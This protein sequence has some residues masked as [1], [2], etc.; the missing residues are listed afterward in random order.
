MDIQNSL[1][2][3]QASR[4]WSTPTPAPSDSLQGMDSAFSRLASPTSNDTIRP[5]SFGKFGGGVAWSGSSTFVLVDD[6]NSV[7]GGLI[8]AGARFCLKKRGECN[9]RS[10]SR[11]RFE[12]MQSGI[13]I[14]GVKEDAFCHPSVDADKF[15]P[16]ALQHVLNTCFDDI[17]EARRH[18]ELL[19]G[20]EKAL[21]SSEDVINL[22]QA[23]SKIEAFTP[24]KKRLKIGHL[25][26][27]LDQALEAEEK[28]PVTGEEI[29]PLKEQPMSLYLTE[30]TSKV[31]ETQQDF[32]SVLDELQ[33]IKSQIGLAPKAGPVSL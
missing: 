33:E 10:H 4:F 28:P 12:E 18:V 31:E 3:A 9:V 11:K 30:L 2:K 5:L 1:K 8:G 25:R 27:K 7:W 22:V 6:C 13:F 16:E 23:K 20:V 26:T 17:M 15:F 21:Q 24:V 19:K 14:R 29:P 32:A